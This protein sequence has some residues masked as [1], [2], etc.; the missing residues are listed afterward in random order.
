MGYSLSTIL[1]RFE[2]D[3]AVL[4]TPFGQEIFWPR[5]SVPK[6]YTLGSTIMLSLSENK[7]LVPEHPKKSAP[8]TQKKVSIDTLPQN[9][10]ESLARAMLEELLNG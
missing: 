9:E 6:E 7:E 5:K 3:K 1:D 10:R 4:I 2:K 8:D